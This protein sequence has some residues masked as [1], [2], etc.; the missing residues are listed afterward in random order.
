MTGEQT[1]GLTL[2]LARA[3]SAGQAW[4]DLRP[5]SKATVRL[6]APALAVALDELAEALDA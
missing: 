3:A 1:T 4:A 2:L 5:S 6:D